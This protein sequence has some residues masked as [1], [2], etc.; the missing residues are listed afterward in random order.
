MPKVFGDPV[1]RLF[2]LPNVGVVASRAPGL[3][4][5]CLASVLVSLSASL[6]AHTQ[7]GSLE[8]LAQG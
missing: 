1:P 8:H 5:V 2:S 3:L 6:K 4:G 7:P